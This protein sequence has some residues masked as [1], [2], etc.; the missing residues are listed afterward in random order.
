[1]AELTQRTLILCRRQV[2]NDLT[3]RHLH[4]IKA[5]A[6]LDIPADGIRQLGIVFLRVL[7][8]HH[9]ISL[10]L[11]NLL[12]SLL[13]RQ[14]ALHNT[15]MGDDRLVV[16][17][18]Q[19]EVI[20]ECQQHQHQHTEPER[21]TPVTPLEGIILHILRT[22][23]LIH[24]R[25]IHLDGEHLQRQTLTLI[26]LAINLHRHRWQII[27]RVVE[28]CQ[29][30]DHRSGHKPIIQLFLLQLLASQHLHTWCDILRRL[31]LGEFY[32]RIFLGIGCQCDVR[33]L[34]HKDL[35]GVDH[36]LHTHLSLR[37]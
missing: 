11:L 10:D 2:R 4:R 17:Q 34:A 36:R 35:Y 23:E 29:G 9:L 1:M 33:L 3:T 8:G 24:V 7:R 16:T 6:L 20:T 27:E 37:R 15:D 19:I 25:G 12:H 13:V 5:I 18:S 28:R 32:L 21:E 22:K 14:Q 31:E 30:I 26:G